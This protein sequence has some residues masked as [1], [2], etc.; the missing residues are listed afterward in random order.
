[1]GQ[2]ESL[3]A[4]PALS[5]AHAAAW[6]A[7]KE[8]LL[9]I[10]RDGMFAVLGLLRLACWSQTSHVSST[11]LHTFTI[12]ENTHVFSMTLITVPC[13][14]LVISLWFSVGQFSKWNIYCFLLAYYSLNWR[15]FLINHYFISPRKHL[16]DI[17]TGHITTVEQQKP[18]SQQKTSF[19]HGAC[20]S[21]CAHSIGKVFLCYMVLF[22]A[23]IF[24]VETRSCLILSAPM[25]YKHWPNKK[26]NMVS[27]RGKKWPKE[28]WLNK[29]ERVSCI[30]S[31]IKKGLCTQKKE[32]ILLDRW[33]NGWLFRGMRKLH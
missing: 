19:E 7:A 3:Q 21:P 5:A 31:D 26:G 22:R 33:W 12:K 20:R 8:G 14:F 15:T 32:F 23:S 10:W 9:A 1:M 25:Y 29:Y 2:N 11:L 17:K 30:H 18:G 28:E 16:H 27:K 13:T 24:F 4:H 6:A